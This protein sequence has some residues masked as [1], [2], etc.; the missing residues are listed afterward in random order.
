[1]NGDG[2]YTVNDF[3]DM[4]N[5]DIL[6][7]NGG[8]KFDVVLMNPPYS[9]VNP[10]DGL[11]IDFLNKCIE[12]SDV[13]ISI[14]PDPA[15]LSHNKGNYSSKNKIKELREYVN[16]LHPS[17]EQ[18]ENLFDAGIKS[19][20]II[21]KFDNNNIP[22]KIHVKFKNGHEDYFDKQEDIK[23]IQSKYFE[24]FYLKL[25][26]Y[27][28]INTDNIYDHI[29]VGPGYVKTIKKMQI[30]RIKD[31]NNIDKNK[32]YVFLYSPD[33]SFNGTIYKSINK[34]YSGVEFDEKYF[35]KNNLFVT[36]NKNEQ[37]QSSNFCSYMMTDFIKLIKKL[38]IAYIHDYDIYDYMPWLDF[39]KSYTDEELFEMIGMKYN[40]EEINK[41]LNES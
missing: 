7:E 33:A 6:K 8:K 30:K 12:I 3:L 37:K 32:L 40:K 18:I 27:L 1:M 39:S 4:N 5:E 29:S 13:L 25:K 11:Y 35:N 31:I 19:N 24:D 34:A 9:K 22:E 36:F 26:E 23:T 16:K 10:G 17:V 21:C 28:N 20:I 2:K 38:T 14:N 41:I 15:I